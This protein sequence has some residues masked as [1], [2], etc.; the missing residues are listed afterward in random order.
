M[1]AKSKTLLR[2]STFENSNDWDL[3]T[4]YRPQMSAPIHAGSSPFR[5]VRSKDA[6][7]QIQSS[8][9]YSLDVKT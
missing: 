7:V 2:T 4:L 8:L 1:S 5:F 3:S 9:T 6:R